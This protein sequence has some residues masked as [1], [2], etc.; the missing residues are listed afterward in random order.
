[1][2]GKGVSGEGDELEEMGRGGRDKEEGT[3]CDGKEY[4]G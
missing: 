4:D 2:R 3:E 1:M